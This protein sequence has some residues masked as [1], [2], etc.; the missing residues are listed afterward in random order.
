MEVW[1]DS[2]TDQV[3]AVYS[4]PTRS[5][6]WSDQGFVRADM[7]DRAEGKVDRNFIATVADGVVTSVRRNTNP[8]QP[9]PPPVDQTRAD[10]ITRLKD[11]PAMADLVKVLRL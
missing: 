11:D 10:A 3:M 7:A 5:T 4:K 9:A 8:V 6:A 1:I 2:T